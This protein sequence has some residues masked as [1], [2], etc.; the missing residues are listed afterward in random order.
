MSGALLLLFGMLFS[1]HL[2]LTRLKKEISWSL[3]V[4]VT[5][6]FVVVRGVENVGVTALFG[7]FLLHLSNANQF[8]DVL[9]VAGGTALGSNL[10]NNLPM[11]LVIVS[12]LNHSQMAPVLHQMLVFAAILG[13]DL[14]PNLTIVGSLAA[15]LWILLLRRKGLE[16]ST[17]EY[18]KLG[19]ILVPAL[20]VLGSLLIWFKL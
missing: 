14:G 15:M 11:A 9:A 2:E 5:G 4:F 8:S 3:F 19:M 13:A 17:I 16:V 18:F 7:S 12:T 1:H 20:I 6:M 10:I